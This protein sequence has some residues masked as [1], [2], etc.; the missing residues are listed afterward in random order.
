MSSVAAVRTYPGPNSASDFQRVLPSSRASAW[1][2][3]ARTGDD[4]VAGDRR[5]GDE[6]S[7]GLDVPQP[8][9]VGRRQR[10][11]GAAAGD[12]HPSVGHDRC[13]REL[14]RRRR[15]LLGHTGRRTRGVR[16]VTGPSDIVARVRPPADVRKR[17]VRRAATRRRRRAPTGARRCRRSVTGARLGQPVRATP[18]FGRRL[19]TAR[20]PG[21]ADDTATGERAQYPSSTGA[22]HVAPPSERPRALRRFPFTPSSPRRNALSVDGRR[23]PA[24]PDIVFR[25]SRTCACCCRSHGLMS[26]CFAYR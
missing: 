13:R 1:S 20:T 7:V 12:E 21:E 6:L 10:R 11:H 26:L 14:R 22:T 2:S 25:T 18:V 16:S 9:A 19:P 5:R 3:G 8:R 4:G 17:H 15:P 24:S 23:L